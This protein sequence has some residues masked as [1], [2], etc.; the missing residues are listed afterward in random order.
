MDR[1]IT[2]QPDRAAVRFSS[3]V[4]T[5]SS[6]S[7]SFEKMLNDFNENNSTIISKTEPAKVVLVGEITQEKRTV[8]EL[9]MQHDELKK[10]GWN[11]LSSSQNR[12]KDYTNL[13]AGTRIYYDRESGTLSWSGKDQSTPASEVYRNRVQFTPQ[14]IVT[15]QKQEALPVSPAILELGEISNSQPTVSHLLKADQGLGSETWNIL[16]AAPNSTKDFSSLPPGTKVLYDSTTREISWQ[17]P[18]NSVVS[19]PASGEL[20]S[21]AQEASVEPASRT[22]VMQPAPFEQ[23]APANQGQQILLGTIDSNNSTVSHLLM[24]NPEFK[25]QAWQLLNNSVNINK[26]F[27]QIPVGAEVFIEPG[28]MEISWTG[29]EQSRAATPVLSATLVKTVHLENE[30]AESAIPAADLIEAVQPF[31]GKSYKD[32]DC[33][34]LLVKGLRRMD[35]PYEG[36]DGLFNKLTTMAKEKGLPVNAYL[37]GEGIVKAAGTLVLSKSYPRMG[38]WKDDANTLIREME[39]LLDKGQILSFSTEKR[40]HTGIVSQQNDQWTFINSGRLDNSLT[41]NSV[42][43]GV[44]EEVLQDEIRNWFKLAHSKGES[45]SVTLGQLEQQKVL[46]AYNMAG[47]FSRQI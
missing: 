45:L 20:L 23:R 30:F 24:N 7:T 29:G 47:K 38:N 37:N 12:N 31:I 36:K 19:N 16:A 27:N 3:P 40:G 9:L 21:P 5:D 33:Y 4:K 8:S 25:D 39:P 14:P 35:I 18:G 41:D 6:G 15:V 42:S 13:Q 17:L 26:S 11:I 43:R 2:L 28:T 32:I 46:T 10:N 44:G 1:Q 34:E 22:T